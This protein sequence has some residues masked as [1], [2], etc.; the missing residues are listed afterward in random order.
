LQCRS[1]S[2]VQRRLRQR[3]SEPVSSQARM[4]LALLLPGD[5]SLAATTAS[6]H[7]WSAHNAITGHILSD[8]VEIP[9]APAAALRPTSRGFLP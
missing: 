7:D 9:I 6:L 5:P 4:R 2:L 1:V 3:L 8:H